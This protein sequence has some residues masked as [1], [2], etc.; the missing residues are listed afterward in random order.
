MRV[1]QRAVLPSETR[2]G[3]GNAELDAQLPCS[4]VG[5]SDDEMSAF[6]DELLEGPVIHYEDDCREERDNVPVAFEARVP[7]A[8]KTFAAKDYARRHGLVAA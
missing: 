3:W 7:E 4:T 6:I 1:C 8:G 2:R 5:H